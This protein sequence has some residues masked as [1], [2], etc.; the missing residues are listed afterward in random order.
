MSN[1]SVTE[2]YSVINQ[3]RDGECARCLKTFCE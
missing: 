2:V 3:I 1:Q